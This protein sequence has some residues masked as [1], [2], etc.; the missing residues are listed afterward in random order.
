M[1]KIVWYDTNKI[2]EF[3][4]DSE[5]FGMNEIVFSQPSFVFIYLYTGICT[6]V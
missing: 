3:F 1:W 4:E 5:F 2:V 6:K